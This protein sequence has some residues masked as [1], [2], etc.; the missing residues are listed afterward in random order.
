LSRVFY[1]FPLVF[2]LVYYG[3]SQSLKSLEDDKY[4]EKYINDNTGTLWVYHKENLE[5][6]LKDY[7]VSSGTH[8]IVWIVT[9]TGQKTLEQKSFE[10]AGILGIGKKGMENSALLFIVL[11]TRLMRIET[12][13]GLRDAFSDEICTAIFK[14]EIIPRFKLKDYYE[15]IDAGIDA[16]MKACRGEYKIIETD[17][18]E[19][20]DKPFLNAG[21]AV[22]AAF[23]LLIVLFIGYTVLVHFFDSGS[24]KAG[25]FS[26]RG[27][28]RDRKITEK[29][30]KYVSK[31]SDWDYIG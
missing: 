28:G 4:F 26:F 6:K 7:A 13:S 18:S 2:S 25:K 21:T 24:A 16:M 11:N 15:G 19:Q 20:D 1:I 8:I 14:T 27:T 30:S 5:Q 17:E 3:N 31:K 10:T 29:P 23:F 22:I 9:N 12:G